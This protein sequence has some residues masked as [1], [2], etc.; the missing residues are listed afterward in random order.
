MIRG[1]G[2][3]LVEHWASVQYKSRYRTCLEAFCSDDRE[4][5][6]DNAVHEE[7]SQYKV[8]D[9]RACRKCGYAIGSKQDES[10]S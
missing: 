4:A 5:S 3:I 7:T 10:S 2:V 8:C 9:V 1:I 6:R